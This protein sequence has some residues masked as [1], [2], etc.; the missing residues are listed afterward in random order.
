MDH[1]STHLSSQDAPPT[2]GFHRQSPSAPWETWGRAGRILTSGLGVPPSGKMG[3]FFPSGLEVGGGDPLWWG[4]AGTQEGGPCGHQALQN[5]L[6]RKGYIL[7]FPEHLLLPPG[8]STTWSHPRDLR[9]PPSPFEPAEGPGQVHPRAPCWGHTP[10]LSA[11]PD[12]PPR[13][14]WFCMLISNLAHIYKSITRNPIRQ[15]LRE[16]WWPVLQTLPSPSPS[17]EAWPWRG[18]VTTPE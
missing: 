11:R 7:P 12:P 18:S 8:R 17:T 9:A 2:H 14:P 10:C 5:P 6:E 4:W 3:V 1:C 15:H 16:G 13:P